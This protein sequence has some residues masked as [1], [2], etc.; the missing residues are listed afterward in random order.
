MIVLENEKRTCFENMQL[1]AHHL[2]CMKQGDEP[3][4]HF[5]DWKRPSVTYGALA[6]P[7]DF[8]NFHALEKLGID[9][10][11]R[12]T[13]GGMIF[14]VYDLAF[15]LVVPASHPLYKDNVL[16]NY[17]WV[18]RI[19]QEAL[20]VPSQLLEVESISH[21]SPLSQFCMSKGTRYDL[22]LE[23]KKVYG[24]AQRRK[25][26]AFLHQASVSLFEPDFDMLSNLFLEPGP[27]ISAMKSTSA[28]LFKG[29]KVNASLKINVHQNLKSIFKKAF[30]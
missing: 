7:K 19:V 3:I 29:E 22:M 30:I 21:K 16:D 25:K 18:N 12:A 14:H 9:S 28:Y 8:L 17:L 1:D 24:A 15:S 27:I 2:S 11:K 10:A 13:G 5:Y 26:N 4:L 20:E 6:K 23:D